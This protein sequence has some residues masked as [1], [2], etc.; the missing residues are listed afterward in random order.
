MHQDEGGNKA[1][2]SCHCCFL[3]GNMQHWRPYTGGCSP[4]KSLQL[5]WMT[6]TWSW[7]HA[8]IRVHGGKTHVWNGAGTKPEACDV[9][10]QRA[11]ALDPES[12][13]RV[14]RGSEVPTTEQRIIVLG[15]PLAH[16]DFVREHLERTREKHRVLLRRIPIVPETSSRLGFCSS[17]VHRRE[18]I[19][20]CVWSGRSTGSR[21]RSVG[22]LLQHFGGAC[23]RGINRTNVHHSSNGTGRSWVEKR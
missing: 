18:P 12:R 17:I 6:L 2:S 4:Q 1:T 11:E 13:V 14:W 15:T 3:C 21:S 20:C 10:Q 9:L 19:I 7:C 5:S 23:W 16:E 22:M 8:R